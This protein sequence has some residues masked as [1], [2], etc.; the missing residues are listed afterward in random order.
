M[1]ANS[2]SLILE[3]NVHKD[4]KNYEEKS[5]KRVGPGS[6]EGSL[7]FLTIF[8]YLSAVQKAIFADRA[9]L[10]LLIEASVSLFGC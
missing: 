9:R 3:S 6:G 10:L 7:L 8:N 5:G 1:E 2:Q 4:K